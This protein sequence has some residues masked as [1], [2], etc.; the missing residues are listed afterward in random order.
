MVTLD[1]AT[2]GCATVVSPERQQ[3]QSSAY[4]AF[5][6]GLPK[7]EAPDAYEWLEHAEF[8]AYLTGQ[9]RLVPI[10]HKAL[11]VTHRDAKVQC[12]KIICKMCACC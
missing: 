9:L 10:S 12:Q 3:L 11:Q 8:Q 2:N 6:V 4:T 5:L 7:E 1:V